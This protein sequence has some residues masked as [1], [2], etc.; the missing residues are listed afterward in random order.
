M[1]CTGSRCWSA[2]VTGGADD[3][4]AVA[5]RPRWLCLALVIA[6]TLS[7]VVAA[8]AQSP[9]FTPRDEAPE[10]FPP[11]A[12]R[13]ETFHSCTVCHNFKLV[14]AQ[15]MSRRQWEESIA[16]MVA[17]HGMHALDDKDRTIVLDYLEAT[18]PPRAPSGGWQN[19]FLKQ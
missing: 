5:R 12:G 9:Q 14:A 15:G 3:R 11:G 19:P 13:D 8:G 18:F 10:N 4:G 6:G 16:L 7:F 2:D 1:P 17:K